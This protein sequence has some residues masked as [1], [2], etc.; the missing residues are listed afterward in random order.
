VVEI[1]KSCYITIDDENNVATAT[2][3]T[4]IWTTKW[5][6][7]FTVNGYATIAASAGRGIER[8]T[9]YK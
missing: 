4:A 3:V 5:H 9:I 7:L 2:S 8:H 1:E 6:K